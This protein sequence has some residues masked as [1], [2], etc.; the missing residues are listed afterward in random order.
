MDYLREQGF[1]VTDEVSMGTLLI[2]FKMDQGIPAKAF[3]CHT[4]TVDGYALEG[5]VPAADIRRLLDE[6]PDAVG[7]AVPGMPAGSPGME[8][9]TPD[10][11]LMHVDRP[12]LAN[13]K[14][15]RYTLSH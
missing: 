12:L 15:V 10:I 1:T 4:G 11:M 9:G 6:R 8:G 2:R 7:L 5:H 14:S 13:D 3:S